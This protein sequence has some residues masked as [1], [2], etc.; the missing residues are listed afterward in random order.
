MYFECIL[1]FLNDFT[2]FCAIFAVSRTNLMD[3]RPFSAFVI[4]KIMIL[5]GK[6]AIPAFLT[7]KITVSASKNT[8][9]PIT[10]V[11]NDQKVR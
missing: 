9:L 6:N 2:K 11:G 1:L 7:G 8:D 5:A 10:K 3:F 4:S